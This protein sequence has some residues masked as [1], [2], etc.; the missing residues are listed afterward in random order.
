MA[1]KSKILKK[2]QY[3]SFFNHGLSKSGSEDWRDWISSSETKK[4]AINV[5]KNKS[6]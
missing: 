5:I 3:K 2:N 6:K 1:S 4:N